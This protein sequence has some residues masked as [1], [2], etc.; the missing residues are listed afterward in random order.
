MFNL[1]TAE[2]HAILEQLEQAMRSHRTWFA[3]L[4]RSL[5]CHLPRLADDVEIDDERRCQFGQWLYQFANPRLR[6]HPAFVAIETHH[7]EMHAAASRLINALIKNESVEVADYDNFSG[8]LEQ[9]RFEMEEL[10]REL[11]EA[12]YNRDPLTGANTRKGLL[13]LLREHIEL[14]RRD[15]QHTCIA[16]L[17]FDHFKSVN[18][19]Y[20][21]P[22]GDKV[23]KTVIQH[24]IQHSRVYDKIFRYGG[25]EFII[26]LP[27]TDL[28]MAREIVERLRQGIESLEVAI[29]EAGPIRITASFGLTSLDPAVPVD[30]IIARADRATYA[31]KAAGRNRVMVWEA[32]RDTPL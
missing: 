21:H 7:T 4:N 10:T 12:L 28:P 27:G 5:V 30:E 20:G 6:K 31:A 2:L 17:D 11:Q 8:R 13:S 14:A 18:D 19:R 16:L 1:S 32:E 9:L 23:L 3:D 22:A 29:P 15:V 25:E 26:V 24:I